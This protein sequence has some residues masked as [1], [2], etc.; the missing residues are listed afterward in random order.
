MGQVEDLAIFNDTVHQRKYGS[1][2]S[3]RF[4]DHGQ[5]HE[6]SSLRWYEAKYK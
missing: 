5:G 1:L 6:L 4:L 3:L 2:T